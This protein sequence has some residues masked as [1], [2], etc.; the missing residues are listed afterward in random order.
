MKKV[1]TRRTQVRKKTQNKQ[2][3]TLNPKTKLDLSALF[4]VL[5]KYNLSKYSKCCPSNINK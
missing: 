3:P 2:K 4:V 1:K 5:K